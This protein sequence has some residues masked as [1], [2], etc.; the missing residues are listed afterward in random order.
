MPCDYVLKRVWVFNSVVQTGGF[1]LMVVNILAM[2]ICIDSSVSV[3]LSTCFLYTVVNL[4]FKFSSKIVN[5]YFLHYCG[6]AKLYF[7]HW[8]SCLFLL[9]HTYMCG[10]CVCVYWWSY[11]CA[12]KRRGLSEPSLFSLGNTGPPPLF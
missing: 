10:M 8:P 6:G 7:F 1:S 3:C 12:Q 9:G 4:F 5:T 11:A 2:I